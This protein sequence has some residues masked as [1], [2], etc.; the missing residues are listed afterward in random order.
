MASKLSLLYHTSLGIINTYG[1]S[2]FLRIAVYELKNQG[3]DLFRN[4]T[5]DYFS[6]L[7]SRIDSQEE[8]YNRYIEN[9]D[10]EIS[11]NISQNKE[12]T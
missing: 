3:F 1:L 5:L 7:E 9:F 2:Y 6:E 12:D 11:R 10:L 8:L 4:P